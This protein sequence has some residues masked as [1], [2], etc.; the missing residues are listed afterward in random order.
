MSATKR[1][2]TLN[3]TYSKGSKTKWMLYERNWREEWMKD[4]SSARLSTTRSYRV[5]RTQRRV[6]K[7]S[8][9]LRETSWR[10]HTKL[11]QELLNLEE[12]WWLAPPQ[13]WEP[14][15]WA[16]QQP[17]EGTREDI[18]ISNPLDIRDGAPIHLN[19]FIPKQ[20]G[21]WGKLKQQAG[22]CEK[23]AAKA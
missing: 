12:A 11:D 2:C 13:E 10:R 5:T 8:K 7:I 17:Q 20:A 22:R 23:D 16:N 9:L 21:P 14:L 18:V 19:F 4:L 6:L 1:S 3:K 15:R